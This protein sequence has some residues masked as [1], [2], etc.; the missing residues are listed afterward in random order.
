MATFV[1]LCLFEYKKMHF[2][3]SSGFRM[4][5]DSFVNIVMKHRVLSDC[6]LLK[7]DLAPWKAVRW[8]PRS[9][10]A[11]NRSVSILRSLGKFRF[12]GNKLTWNE[13][14]LFHF[15]KYSTDSAETS[16]CGCVGGRGL[17]PKVDGAN[18]VLDCMLVR[19]N[20]LPQCRR[21]DLGL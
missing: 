7:K 20:S 3:T 16:N 8:L 11:L 6:R 15:R 10:H 14:V 19:H 4:M 2:R 21:T 17:I 5:I 18:L 13:R 9:T 12:Y 1:I